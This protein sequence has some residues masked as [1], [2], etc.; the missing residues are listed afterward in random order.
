MSD[1]VVQKLLEH[2]FERV[3]YIE[4]KVKEEGKWGCEICRKC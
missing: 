3:E 2:D 1:G 4:K